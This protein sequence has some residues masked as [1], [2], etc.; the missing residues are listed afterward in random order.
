MKGGDTMNLLGIF[1]ITFKKSEVD[2]LAKEL[3]K[4][5]NWI[6]PKYIGPQAEKVTLGKVRIDRD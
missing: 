4:P 3:K 5:E 2:H 6:P 1:A